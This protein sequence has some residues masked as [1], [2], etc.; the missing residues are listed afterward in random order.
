MLGMQASTGVV[1]TLLQHADQ[2]LSFA[3]AGEYANPAQLLQ[4]L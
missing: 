3:A 1:Q 2:V 4:L